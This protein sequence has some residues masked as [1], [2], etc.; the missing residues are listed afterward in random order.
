MAC[1]SAGTLRLPQLSASASL[2]SRF[3][4]LCTLRTCASHVLCAWRRSE[5]L[6]GLFVPPP[7]ALLSNTA[8]AHLVP[9]WMQ[10]ER[11]QPIQVR[12][13]TMIH[14]RMHA[15]FRLHVAVVSR[16][17]HCSRAAVNGS[18]DELPDLQGVH[19]WLSTRCHG[20]ER[21]L[22]DAWQPLMAAAFNVLDG[23]MLDGWSCSNSW[24]GAMTM[25]LRLLP[26]A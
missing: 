16:R 20:H 9:R 8:A 25:A 18:G 14:D 12:P 1:L 4:T 3:C 7:L 5:Q 10:K 23:S 21:A 6:S 2:I 24:R 13:R 15:L 11:A 26:G 17:S 22:L 19:G